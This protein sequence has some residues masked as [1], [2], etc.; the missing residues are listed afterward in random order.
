MARTSSHGL[1]FFPPQP[2]LGRVAEVAP[3]PQ[4]SIGRDAPPAFQ[5]AGDAGLRNVQVL[6]QA[7]GGE[8][9]LVQEF[10]L[11]DFAGVNFV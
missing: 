5:D 10:L 8:V 3:Q 1:L 11:Q 7:V 2:E 6:G 4:G 9:E